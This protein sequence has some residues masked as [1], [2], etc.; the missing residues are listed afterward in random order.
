M[1]RISEALGP[2]FGFLHYVFV[3]SSLGGL[4]S[5]EQGLKL[6][7]IFVPKAGPYNKSGR[8]RAKSESSFIVYF[9]SLISPFAQS[10]KLKA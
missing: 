5:S 6:R 2:K 3:F 1:S 8:N 9:L 4:S 10:L 7:G